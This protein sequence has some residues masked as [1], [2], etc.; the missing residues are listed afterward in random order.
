[1]SFPGYVALGKQGFY[2]FLAD[3]MIFGS[4]CSS[5]KLG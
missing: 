2:I 5:L 3:S 4:V 1:M